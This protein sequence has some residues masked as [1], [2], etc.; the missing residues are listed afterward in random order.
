MYWKGDFVK[1]LSDQAI[2]VHLKCAA[3]APSELSLMHTIR[4]T[5]Q[6]PGTQLGHSATEINGVPE[7]YS[8]E[9]EIEARSPVSLILALGE[10][11]NVMPSPALCRGF[12]G[13][14]RGARRLEGILR[15]VAAAVS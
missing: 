1:E 7:D 2:D 8:R 6:S 5:A 9:G 13:Q 11:W 3:K 10:R 15:V 12:L 14:R 4:L